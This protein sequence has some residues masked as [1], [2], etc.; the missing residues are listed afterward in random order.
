MSFVI[1]ADLETF[2]ILGGVDE[3]RKLAEL[4]VEIVVVRPLLE[5]LQSDPKSARY[6]VDKILP[7][8]IV[9]TEPVL[10]R[11]PY[12][13]VHAATVDY[14]TGAGRERISAG[15]P[16]VL[17]VPR[18]GSWF[19]RQAQRTFKMLVARK[20]VAARIQRHIAIMA[21]PNP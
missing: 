10:A 7:I 4:G 5:E 6:L 8:Q 19:V 21:D 3:L 20:G 17:V 14:L 16:A 18:P 11:G 12:P 15:E 1:I 13:R 2:R 9:E